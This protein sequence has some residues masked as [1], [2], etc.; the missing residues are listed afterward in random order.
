MAAIAADSNGP[1][2]VGDLVLP[3]I[4]PTERTGD[5][6]GAVGFHP[7]KVEPGDPTVSKEPFVHTDRESEYHPLH[8]GNLTSPQVQPQVSCPI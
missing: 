3:Q 2:S 7:R 4:R 5:V 1:T 8:I 6:A